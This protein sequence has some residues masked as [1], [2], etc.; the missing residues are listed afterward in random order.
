MTPS[1]PTSGPFKLSVA[2][3]ASEPPSQRPRWPGLIVLAAGIFLGS[4]WLIFGFL[5]ALGTKQWWHYPVVLAPGTAI[6]FLVL[7]ARRSP[8]PYGTA[9]AVLGVLPLGLAWLRGGAWLGALLLGLPLVAAGLGFVL[10]KDQFSRQ[11]A[12]VER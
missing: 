2:A 3:R 8:L 6:L 4:F 12:A 7:M 5:S 10:L 11:S 1:E 9:L